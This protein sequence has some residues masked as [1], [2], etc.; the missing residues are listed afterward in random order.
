MADAIAVLR[1]SNT[2]EAALDYGAG[3]KIYQLFGGD[4]CGTNQRSDLQS[5]LRKL[6]Q[7]CQPW[8]LRLSPYGRDKVK[9]ALNQDE[10]QCL[11]EAG[12]FDAVPGADI[13]AWW[14]EI[15]ATVRGAVEAERMIRAREAERLSFEYEMA[16]LESLG[17]NFQPEWVS[18]N[19]NSLGYDIRSY[20][21]S[22]GRI[23]ARLIEVK[24]TTSAEVFI[25][26]NEWQN[27]SGA[28][29]HYFFHVWKLPE[30]QVTEY[31]V[32]SVRSHIPIDQGVGAWENAR[33]RLCK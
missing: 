33:I 13:V 3:E 14:D 1:N 4:P 29:P 23:V 6:I 27:A 17:I 5:T 20:E 26:R 30:K 24:S 21:R 2:D 8:W 16:R 9:S 32:A 19:D 28:E 18:L 31:S 10:I 12:L 22:G 25:T 11:R 7:L 15:A